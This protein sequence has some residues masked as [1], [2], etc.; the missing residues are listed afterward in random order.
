[1]LTPEYMAKVADAS[2]KIAHN[3]HKSILD[4]M[5]KRF[6]AR[7]GREEAFIFTATDKWNMDTIQQAGFLYS[8][9]VRELTLATGESQEEV[10][11]A[12]KKAGAKALSN[13]QKIYDQVGIDKPKRIEE[14]PEYKRIVQRNYEATSGDMVN[15]T[16]TTADVAQQTFINQCDTV[17]TEVM[18]GAKTTEQAIADA[19]GKMSM[20]GV[21]V[22]YPSGAKAKLETAIARCVRTGVAQTAG[23][24]SEQR[25]KEV[26]CEH[27]LVTSHMGARPS[28]QVWQGKV[29][30]I[31]GSD[32]KYQN[33]KDVTGYGTGSGLCGW[34]C[35]HS[36]TPFFPDLM[37]NNFEH[38]KVT[39]NKEA[40]EK[41]Q[42]QKRI[43]RVKRDADR[44]RQA[45]KTA[46][47]N[48]DNPKLR[49]EIKSRQ[50]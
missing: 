10:E 4:Q 17:Y 23:Q 12:L 33:F 42:E 24:I 50:I 37:E 6:L 2:E 27:Y 22:T 31:N 11:N 1:M 16:R 32:D 9:I 7:L 5:I 36:F 34:N 40:Y 21:Y 13:D 18:H 26:G 38:Y 46:I 48:T 44:K 19:I 30:K 8:D 35:R 15:L 29:F 39:E 41:R 45:Y 49:K 14:S 43:E 47:K 25:A 20:D 28:H 3:L